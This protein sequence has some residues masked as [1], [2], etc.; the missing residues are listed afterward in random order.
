MEIGSRTVF[1]LKVINFFQQMTLVAH[2]RTRH[3]NVWQLFGFTAAPGLHT[4]IYY[5]GKHLP[6]RASSSCDN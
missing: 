4:L 1:A 2:G 3:P 5:D 6:A